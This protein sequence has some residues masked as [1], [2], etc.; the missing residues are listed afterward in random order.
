M[1]NNR[2]IKSCAIMLVV[3][4]TVWSLF[5]DARER[6]DRDISARESVPDVLPLP[7]WREITRKQ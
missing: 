6:V 2:Y 3:I 7:L 4:G 1:G 5:S